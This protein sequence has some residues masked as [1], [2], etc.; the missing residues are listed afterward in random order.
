[1]A[2]I[3]D[4]EIRAA[5]RKIQAGR[6]RIVLKDGYGRGGGRLS[7]MLRPAKHGVTAEWYATQHKAG[8]RS[9]AKIGVYPQLTL[10]QARDQFASYSVAIR[11]GKPIKRVRKPTDSLRAMLTAYVASL[12]P[13]AQYENRRVLLDSSQSAAA[14]IGGDKRAADVTTADVI[15]WLRTFVERGSLGAAVSARKKLSAAFSWAI[16]SAND[17]RQAGCDWGVTA[18]PVSPIPIDKSAIGVGQRFLSSVEFR[19]FWR[20]L[21]DKRTL[22][23]RCLQLIAI[24]G[25]RAGEITSLQPGQYD[26]KALFWPTTKSGKPHHLPVPLLGVEIL[27]EVKT[28]MFAGVKIQHLRQLCDAFCRQNGV[29]AFTPRDLRRTWKTLA[30]E[31]GLSKADRDLIQNHIN[32]DIS[33]VHYDRYQYWREKQTAIACWDSWID[34]LFTDQSPA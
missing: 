8:K 3:Q 13:R 27:E 34:H 23:A 11:S 12:K 24:S 1:M 7:L 15:E 19:Q 28:R 29:P 32:R 31:A 25:Q 18:N 20:W 2:A 9:L 22:P 33:S 6:K 21:D 17:Y 5:I 10:A 30:G 4:A 16:G 14:V 26:G